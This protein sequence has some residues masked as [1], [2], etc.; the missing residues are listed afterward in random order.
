MF[1]LR[2]A[3]RSPA[4]R[5]WGS[6]RTPQGQL[7]AEKKLRSAAAE[8]PR[9]VPRRLCDGKLATTAARPEEKQP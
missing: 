1:D 5:Y 7:S 9:Y 3:R 2:V 4:R 8:P 6:P